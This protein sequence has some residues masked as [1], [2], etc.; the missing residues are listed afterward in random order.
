MAN[1]ILVPVDYSENALSAARYAISLAKLLNWEI[2]LLHAYQPFTSAFQ[3][4]LAN[5]TDKER[6]AIGAHK[7]MSEFLAKLEGSENLQVQSTLFEG[8]LP[9]SVE[10]AC[11]ASDIGLIVMGTHGAS[12]VRAD[13]LGSNTYH[14]AQST[15]KPL[16]VVPPHYVMKGSLH[17]VFFTDY[18]Q[19]DVYTSKTFTN[20]FQQQFSTLSIAHI[21]SG[22]DVAA[23]SLSKLESWAQSLNPI[24]QNE[25]DATILDLPET[26]ETINQILDKSS[27]DMC[28][29]TLAH[30]RN[31]FENLFQKSLAKAIIMN[32]C[33]PVFL[34]G[35]T[36]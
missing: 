35:K 32:P 23:E 8:T 3:S 6:A 10:Q 22:D 33:C 2:Q 17:A 21:L 4:P 28:L 24:F 30:D 13:L 11:D 26:V 20:I 16:V 29:L 19:D 34:A 31:F 1:T 12:G 7:G 27:A 18:H 36:P 5:K 15:T 14:V 9:E 25:L